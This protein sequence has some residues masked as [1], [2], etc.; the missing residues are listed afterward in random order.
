MKSAKSVASVETTCIGESDKQ[1]NSAGLGAERADSSD[2]AMPAESDAVCGNRESVMT[3]P[4]T[5]A[6]RVGSRMGLRPFSREI[7]PVR[8]AL[9][10]ACHG[11]HHPSSIAPPERTGAAERGSLRKRAK[12][13]RLGSMSLTNAPEVGLCALTRWRAARLAPPQGENQFVLA[14]ISESFWMSPE[15][16]L[17]V[18]L[19][20]NTAM[21]LPLRVL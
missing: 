16:T 10:S 21:S 11:R 5:P 19:E 14:A 3:E 7:P 2:S 18:I 9:R 4:K 12:C 15:T 20:L 6:R 8:H 1:I 17:I 13:G